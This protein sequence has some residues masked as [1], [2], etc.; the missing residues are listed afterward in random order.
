MS[1]EKCTCNDEFATSFCPVHPPE[2]TNKEELNYGES[3]R[4]IIT[5]SDMS[6]QGYGHFE[7]Y[8]FKCPSCGLDA[9]MVNPTMGKCCTNCSV[10]VEI[11][12]KTITAKIRNMSKG[13]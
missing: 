6:P 13:V 3:D 9:I 8:I 2:P 12:S 11:R 5:D 4:L 10:K 7:G 1:E